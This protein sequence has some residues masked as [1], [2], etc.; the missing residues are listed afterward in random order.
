MSKIE[1][2]ISREDTIFSAVVNSNWTIPTVLV[3]SL[4]IPFYAAVTD[5][6]TK[7]FT[8]EGVL[9]TVVPNYSPDSP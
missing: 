5:K 1:E 3:L 2:Y 4:G 6:F 7:P 8:V 9:E